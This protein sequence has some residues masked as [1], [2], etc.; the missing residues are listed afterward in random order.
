M[1]KSAP[2]S[3]Q[4]SVREALPLIEEG[5]QDDAQ[6]AIVRFAEMAKVLV[7]TVVN[8]QLESRRL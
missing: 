3:P 1:Q 6:W 5:Q 8:G 4:A 2:T 7:D